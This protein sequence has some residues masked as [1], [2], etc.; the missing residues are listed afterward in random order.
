MKPNFVHECPDWDY[1]M[2]EPYSLE[3]SVCTCTLCDCGEINEGDC[4][5]YG[6]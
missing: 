1:M 2:I 6:R 5:K 3:W 4:K